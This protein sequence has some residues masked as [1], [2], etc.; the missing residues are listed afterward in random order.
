MMS[1]SSHVY[2]AYDLVWQLF[3]AMKP[4]SN[5]AS[6]VAET[7]ASGVP[8]TAE[9]MEKMSLEGKTVPPADKA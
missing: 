2:L 3:P 6:G 8:Q 9:L 7:P 4:I 5:L 1:R